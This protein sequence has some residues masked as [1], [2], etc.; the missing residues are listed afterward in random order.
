MIFLI[1]LLLILPGRYELEGVWMSFPVS[2]TLSA[3]VTLA[4]IAWQLRAL[5]R[6]NTEHKTDMA[7]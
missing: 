5:S 1:P 4:M 3:L 6:L 7:L 2:D